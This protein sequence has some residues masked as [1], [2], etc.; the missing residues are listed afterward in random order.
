MSELTNEK[1]KEV[2]LEVYSH[3]VVHCSICTNID[4]ISLIENLVNAK[5]PT[6]I[7]SRWKVSKQ[8]AFD[9][10][11]PNPCPCDQKPETH[12]HYLMEC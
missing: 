9:S 5:N 7:R 11:Q 12:K 3:G 6:G 2:L 10:G 8:I 1:K 4:S